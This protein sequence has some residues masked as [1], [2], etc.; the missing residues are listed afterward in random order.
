MSMRKEDKA[1]LVESLVQQLNEYDNFYLADL[2]GLDSEQTTNLRRMLY[3]NGITLRVVKNTLLKRAL[4]EVEYNVDEFEGF[5]AGPTSIMYTEKGNAPA[6][7]IKDYIKKFKTEKPSVKAAY[8][9][10]T[11]YDGE[12]NKLDFLASIK[13]KDELIAD[14]IGLLQSPAKNVVSGLQSGGSKL[15]GILETLSEKS[16]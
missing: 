6:K 3:K 14:L 1:Q 13:S 5:L 4:K 11:V 10:Q 16:E 2:S 9:E 8:I 12:E 15:S 7:V